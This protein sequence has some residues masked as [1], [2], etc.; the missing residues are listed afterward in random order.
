MQ[1]SLSPS[2]SIEPNPILQSALKNKLFIPKIFVNTCFD[3]TEQNLGIAAYQGDVDEI[4]RII[5]LR[6]LNINMLD[7]QS[8]ASVLHY[9]IFCEMQDKGF[10]AFKLL[11]KSGADF[12]LNMNNESTLQLAAER[13]SNLEIIKCL[14]HHGVKIHNLNEKGR[15][16]LHKAVTQLFEKFKYLLILNNAIPLEVK[17]IIIKTSMCL[18]YEHQIPSIK[19][20][21]FNDLM[22]PETAEL[23][24][25][26]ILNRKITVK[27]ED[28]LVLKPKKSFCLIM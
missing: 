25:I 20:I 15:A 19:P 5:H 8:G 23:D 12:Y 13:T 2:F 18:T 26:I 21:C 9:A 10:Q 1:N 4:K 27:T 3:K 11:I 16:N 22:P 24:D 6:I 28:C 17:S 14:I 7:Q